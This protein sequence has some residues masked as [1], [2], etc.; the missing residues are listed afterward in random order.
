LAE[1]IRAADLVV[2]EFV[3]C[4]WIRNQPIGI[5][6]VGSNRHCVASAIPDS[7]GKCQTELW[8]TAIN[9]VKKRFRAEVMR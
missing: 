8:A 9:V 2:V 3:D 7:A 1:A 4:A 6:I 5:H